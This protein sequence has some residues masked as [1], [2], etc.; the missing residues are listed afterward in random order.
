M[1]LAGGTD[2]QFL[3]RIEDGPVTVDQWQI[4]KLALVDRPSTY[5]LVCSGRPGGVPRE[6]VGPV[7]SNSTSGV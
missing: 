3:R 2:A 7:P 6:A 5:L 1:L 4:E